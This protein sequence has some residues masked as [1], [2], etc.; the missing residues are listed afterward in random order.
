M[1]YL[2]LVLFFSL[3]NACVLAPKFETQNNCTGVLR[4]GQKQ[5]RWVCKNPETG[6]TIMI[7]E[8]ANG[9]KDGKL[10][11]FYPTGQTESIS[12]WSK[13]FF[14]GNFK[15]YFINGQRQFEMHYTNGNRSEWLYEWNQ[16]GELI[17]D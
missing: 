12:H 2:I 4:N 10:E 5:G 8:F 6:A 7:A 9:K 13:G 3:L 16:E 15:S 17:E 1:K 11:M 14:H